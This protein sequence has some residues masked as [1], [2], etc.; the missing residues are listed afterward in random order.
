MLP[1]AEAIYT[2]FY[3]V[4]TLFGKCHNL[5]NGGVL[6]KEEIDQLGMQIHIHYFVSN[7]NINHADTNIKQF[8]SYYRTTFPEATVLL[9]MHILEEHDK[10][11]G[12][13]SRNDGE[14]RGREYSCSPEL[15]GDTV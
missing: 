2:Q 8:M 10:K 1:D 7:N 13:R 6:T 14:T 3:K 11:V 9:K 12:N 5:Y 4:F 15:A